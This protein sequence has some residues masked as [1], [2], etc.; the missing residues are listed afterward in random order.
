MVSKLA[1]KSAYR[2]SDVGKLANAIR[3]RSEKENVLDE[4]LEVININKQDYYKILAEYLGNSDEVPADTFKEIIAI[5]EDIHIKQE[6]TLENGNVS[7]FIPNYLR[8]GLCDAIIQAIGE[9]VREETMGRY[10]AALAGEIL[11][12]TI[13]EAI[14][15]L[16]LKKAGSED[17]DMYR[18][19]DGSCEVDLILKNHETH[20]MKLY[21]IKHSDKMIPEQAKHLVN[22]EFV[23][24]IENRLEYKAEGFYVLYNGKNSS[25]T[26]KP[27][28]VFAS[29]KDEGMRLNKSQLAEH[30]ERLEQRAQ[31]EEWGA[32]EVGYRNMTE[33]LCALPIVK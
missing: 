21:E 31:I 30:W 8:Y 3:M 12:G 9:Q 13:Q 25:R 6:I 18:T 26:Y 1:G 33:F 14:C 10:D 20:T 24:E 32:V 16:D 27:D 19:A 28:K 23:R 15:Y 22:R 17:Y 4:E 7:I 2:Y 29:L 5:L 11:K